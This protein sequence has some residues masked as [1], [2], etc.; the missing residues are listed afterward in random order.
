MK[1]NVD[2]LRTTLTTAFAS[3]SDNNLS[4]MDKAE[5]R[6][7]NIDVVANNTAETHTA[8]SVGANL[9]VEVSG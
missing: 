1:N 2:I 3:C 9:F 7:V 8:T 5:I 6:Q 4:W